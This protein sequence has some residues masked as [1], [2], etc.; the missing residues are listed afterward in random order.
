MRKLIYSFFL[1]AMVFSSCQQNGVKDEK[2]IGK[3]S[4]K[5]T[6]DLMTPEVLW[7]YGR[8]GDAQVS[9]DGKT[10]LY[11]VSY[12]SIPENKSNRELFTI[13]IDGKNKIQLTTTA[14]GEYS[15]IWRP[16]G[17][18]ILYLS[19]A[20][21]SMQIWEMN[22]DGSSKNQISD[23]DGDITNIIFS[24]TQ[25]QVLFTK[26]V[27]V[28][29]Q[30]VDIYSDLPKSDGKVITDLMYRHWDTWED[31]KYSHIFIA[32]YADG[33]VNNDYD[34]MENEPYDT[35]L[36]PFGGI[37]E[38]TWSPDGNKVA[39][40]CKKLKG[41][42]Y[43]LSTNS[44]VYIYDLKTKE[45]T[46]LSEGMPGYDRSP[47]FS[48]DGKKIAWLSMSRAGFEADKDRLFV[49]DF[50]TKMKKD[51]TQNFDYSP[52][53]MV[54]TPDNKSMYFVSGVK[55]TFQIYK[56][57]FDNDEI[58]AITKGTH[59]YHSVALAENCLIGTKV[60]MIKPAEIY[61]VDEKTG[62]ETEISFENKEIL[63]QIAPAKVE[64]RWVTTT[65]NK[66]MLTWVIYPPNFDKTKKYPTLLFCEGGPQ[67]PLS[68][69][70]SYRWNF[71]IMAAQ[72]YI[73]VAPN[74]RGVLTFGQE[75]TD[76]ISKDHGGQN[77][78]DYFSAIDDLKKEPFVD[79][80]N[81]GAVGASYGGYSVY[82][83]AGNHNKRFKAF[84]S[85]DGVFNSTAEYG[86]TD[87]MFF[88]DWENG[89]AY[90][91]LNN[92][93]AQNSYANSPHKFAQNWDT[94]ILIIHGGKD[95]RIPYTQGMEAFNAAQ[96][97]GVPSEFLY[98]P[99]ENHWVLRPQNG[100]L[101]Q[102]TFFNWLDRWLKP[103]E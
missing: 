24:P 42:A 65:D 38:I 67:S 103:K 48:T 15:A 101:W 57:N 18:K 10:V 13:G 83:L 35:P 32:D 40:D 91:D 56:I 60:S 55:A 84:I 95:F 64:A 3:K 34:I 52:F 87:E 2:I 43:T 54:W 41:K 93:V 96:L 21:G 82:W 70:W 79:E 20:S 61:R 68:Q 23:V 46:N 14:C 89:G 53:S 36:M 30:V 69:F 98:F 6:S 25:K 33:S 92:K 8:L 77:M 59:D 75:W 100:I 31:G 102:R 16:D 86:S 37:E 85:H 81:L 62:A 28:D 71:S 19:P 63:D 9:P 22:L 80:N 78:K 49:Y 27:K 51:H 90:W 1:L 76:Q 99:S 58:T 47:L 12:Y 4:L 29:K 11:G 88:D 73:V 45:T 74:R 17:K 66:Q 39:Y 44:D 26:D 94:P 72:G 97:R 50:D 5:L 7:S